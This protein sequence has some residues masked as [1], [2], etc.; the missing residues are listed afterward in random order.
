MSMDME[1]GLETAAPEMTPR[2]S[3]ITPTRTLWTVLADEKLHPTD[4]LVHVMLGLMHQVATIH[5]TGQVAQITLDSVGELED[6]R[7]ILVDPVGTP[8]TTNLKKILEVQP[9]I[10]SA[11]KLVGNYRVTQDEASG[12]KIDD[13][14]VLDG[15]EFEVTQ[16]V[17][18]TRLRNWETELGHHD[19]ITDVFQLGMVLAA[20]A[21]GLDLTVHEEIER[22]SLNRTNLF[23]IAPRLHPVIA[24]LILEMTELNRHERATDVAELARR[25]DTW[26]DQPTG[27]EVERVLAEA[28][29]V[30]GRR[31]AVL[32][33]LRDR[34]FDLSRRNR[35]IHFRSTHSS[36]N[37]TDASMP[38][39]MRIESVRA[40]SL[41]T[42]KGQFT[43]DVLSGKAVPLNRWL[44]FEDQPQI[45]SQFDRIIQENR[46]NRNEY[47]FSSLRLT[48]AFLNWHNL[49]EAPNERISSPLLW[50]PV[51]VVRR[52]GVRD[53]Y[54]LT[55]PDPVAEFNPA[56]RHMLRQLYNIELPETV[57][58][59]Q[60][61]LSAIHE[62]I[63][64][65]IHDSEPGVRLELQER[66]AIR[67]ILQRAVQRVN[68]F[69]R[70][71]SGAK[72]TISAKADFSYAR[73]DYRPLGLAL[74]EKFVKPDA[75][76]QRLAAGG[77]LGSS[78]PTFMVA[79]TESMTYGKVG[80]EGHKFAWDID[81]TQVTLANF[82]YRKMSL[83]RD[84]NMLIDTP[85][86][87]PAFDQVFSIDPRPFVEN[88]PPPIPP[89]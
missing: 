30:P 19:E 10:S 78:S 55:C 72:Q 16:P 74:F 31:T 70:R 53:N 6:G 11:L 20:L 60:T 54:T 18:I 21:C 84:Y 85:E 41:C 79:E 35:L 77:S 36:I 51:E 62:A 44:R 15:D 61:S 26:R 25:L 28:Q 86:T 64:T 73:D 83:V 40:D 34:L 81:L 32:A 48:I 2:A 4:D 5:S 45:P 7:L 63:R 8:P 42:W 87:Q 9:Q 24:S 57:D 49:K 1:T 47:G 59:S 23:T 46:R 68:S 43:Q 13:L 71:R 38:M 89:T 3:G 80:S 67:L 58:L 27:I 39:V 52:K 29:N 14:S 56:L 66:P 75:L 17:Y 82:N 65:Q 69:N 76:P 22:F 88:T 37:F 33:H 12:S 50:L